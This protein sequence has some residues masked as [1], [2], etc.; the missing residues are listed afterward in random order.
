MLAPRVLPCLI[1]SFAL[2]SGSPGCRRAGDGEPHPSASACAAQTPAPA[3][4]A[5]PTPPPATSASRAVADAEATAAPAGDV[6]VE[7]CE[8]TKPL[9][10]AAHARCV[11]ECREMRSS[12]HCR[13]QMDGFLAC[14]LRHPVDRWECVE[15]GTASIK[16]GFCDPEQEAYIVCVARTLR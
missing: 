16:E 5:A 7:L 3:A 12:E 6:C 14:L 9:H 1:A 13:A 11:A 8:L 4:L 10:C 2:L 15:D